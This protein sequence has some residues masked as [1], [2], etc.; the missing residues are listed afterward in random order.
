ME[1]SYTNIAITL[2]FVLVVILLVMEISYIRL[3]WRQCVPHV[4]CNP[5]FN[6]SIHKFEWYSEALL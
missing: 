3:E 4:S 1:V 6:G 2:G 5:Y